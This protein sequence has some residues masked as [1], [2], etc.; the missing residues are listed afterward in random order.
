MQK[1]GRVGFGPYKGV[2]RAKIGDDNTND[3]ILPK[4]LKIASLRL[5]IAKPYLLYP[6]TPI[7]WKLKSVSILLIIFITHGHF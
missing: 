4:L 7:P 1:M 5:K 6:Y 2:G 3:R